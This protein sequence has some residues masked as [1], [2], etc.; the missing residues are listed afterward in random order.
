MHQNQ[1]GNVGRGTMN[2]ERELD[3]FP[4]RHMEEQ[5]THTWLECLNVPA[6]YI[7]IILDWPPGM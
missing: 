4:H 3:P 7:H 5:Q 6:E 1:S 2:Y